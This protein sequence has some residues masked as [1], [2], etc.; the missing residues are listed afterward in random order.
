MEAYALNAVGWYSAHLGDYDTARTHCEAALAMCRDDNPYGK[1][2]RLDSLGYIEHSTG[3]HDLAIERY[4]EALSLF[5]TVGSSYDSADT[6]DNLGHPHAALGQH[7]HAR[8]VWR[9]A[10]E[11]YRRQG[12]AEDAERVQ[13]QLHRHLTAGGKLPR[14]RSE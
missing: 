3:H 10:L 12:R 6:L 4:Q 2:H 14:P 7:E 1:A 9:Q 5:R 13:R 8:A 11:L